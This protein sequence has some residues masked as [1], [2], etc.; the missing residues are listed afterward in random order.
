MKRILIASDH[1]G[2][3]LKEK[4]KSYL[5]K[6]GLLVKDLGTHSERR[7]DYPA[8]A[9]KLAKEI[10]ERRY[11]RGILICKTGIGNSIVANR[12]PGV[13]AALCYNVKQARLSRQHNDS[14]ILV[15]GAQFVKARLAERILKVWLKT[16][17]KGGRHLRR[18]KQIKKIEK[19]IR[20][21][22]R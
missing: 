8:F 4:L 11:S 12:L 5:V 20:R 3:R 15:L 6:Q 10:S 22:I 14:N 2:F 16:K 1:A 17:F 18:L 19:Q 7:C 9:Y 13:R 21:K